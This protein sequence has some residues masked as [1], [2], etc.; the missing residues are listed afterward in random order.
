[1]SPKERI[2]FTALL[3]VMVALVFFVGSQEDSVCMNMGDPGLKSK[4]A[5]ADR[6]RCEAIAQ[7]RQS[8]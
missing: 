5:D 4:M 6:T 3:L 8:K 1:M 7:S 2:G